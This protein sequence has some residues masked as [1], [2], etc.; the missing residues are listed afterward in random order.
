MNAEYIN[1]IIPEEIIFISSIEEECCERHKVITKALENK[2]PL[3]VLEGIFVESVK[4]VSA[5]LE[6]IRK[7]NK[8]LEEVLEMSYAKMI[9]LSS[10]YEC[11]I[12]ELRETKRSLDVY[13]KLIRGEILKE[14]NENNRRRKPKWE[15]GRQRIPSE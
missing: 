12:R 3:E 5:V 4:F 8:R 14:I 9:G 11:A 7:K 1:K 10:P 6:V 15:T 13:L 2:V